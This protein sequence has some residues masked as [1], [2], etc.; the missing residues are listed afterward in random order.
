[1]KAVFFDL[2]SGISGD[3]ILAGLLGHCPDRDKALSLLQ[4]ITVSDQFTVKLRKVKRNSINTLH[5]DIKTTA[6]QTHRHLKDIKNIINNSRIS[7]RAKELALAVFT[8]LA[9]CEARVHAQNID[10]IHFHEV[11]AVDSIADIIG[12]AV[13]IDHLKLDKIY[14][15]NFIFGQGSVRIQHGMVQLPV[16]AVDCLT[17]GFVFRTSAV[18]RELV[19]PTGAAILTTLGEQID[20]YNGKVVSTAYSC[21]SRYNDNIAPYCRSV[22]FNTAVPVAKLPFK[23]HKEW[24]IETNIDDDTPENMAYLITKLLQAG[25]RDAYYD[26]VNMKKNRQGFLLKILCGDDQLSVL[27][28]YLLKHSSS[29]GCRTYPVYKNSLYVNIQEKKTSLGKIRVKYA[30][31]PDRDKPLAVN[32]HCKFKLEYEDV[33]AAAG[34][35]N[36]PL[37][38]CREIILN[39]LQQNND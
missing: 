5:A 32:S 23:Q 11:G 7:E 35:H 25:A 30:W 21:G 22:V 27:R 28:E 4:Q 26:T 2:G 34:K 20:Y 16:P 15:N 8:S 33:A 3:M 1:M 14:F 6:V 37:I 36:L 39:E 9:R 19:T 17:A 38:K 18:S 13:L 24:M 29:F 31:N 12:S 10:Q